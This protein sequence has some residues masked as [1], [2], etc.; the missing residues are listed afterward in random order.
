MIWLTRFKSFLIY[1]IYLARAVL[2]LQNIPQYLAIIFFESASLVTYLITSGLKKS[3]RVKKK[4]VAAA[5]KTTDKEHVNV[6]FIGHVDAGEQTR[7]CETVGLQGDPFSQNRQIDHWRADHVPD[8]HGGQ[9]NT[10][11]IREGGEGDQPRDLV[12][13]VVHGHQC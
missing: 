12:P 6:V 4:P 8:E 1:E 3:S 11:E 5:A 7:A 9:A 10:G 2:L 13:L